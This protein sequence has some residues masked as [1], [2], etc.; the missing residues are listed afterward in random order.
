MFLADYRG[1][2]GGHL[3][4]Q[5]APFFHMAEQRRLLVPYEGLSHVKNNRKWPSL[6][7]VSLKSGKVGYEQRK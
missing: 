2:F 1:L 3:N 5:S 7:T 4:L 6:D